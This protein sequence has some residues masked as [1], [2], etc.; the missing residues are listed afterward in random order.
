[1]KPSEASGPFESR[2]PE[3]SW[4]ALSGP[5]SSPEHGEPWDGKTH[6]L[7]LNSIRNA[8]DVRGM[9][10][11]ELCG[12]LQAIR[13]L[14]R[15]KKLEYRLEIIRLII[16]MDASVGPIL[17]DSC[18][19]SERRHPDISPTQVPANSCQM[20]RLKLIFLFG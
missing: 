2:L 7:W 11:N 18:N 13:R 17:V 9:A 5:S 19:T 10:A 12:E 8:N 20:T 16:T 6:R 4:K 3:L 1:M 15:Q 14:H